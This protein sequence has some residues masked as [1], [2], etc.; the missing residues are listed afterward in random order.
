M[1][2]FKNILF[3]WEREVESKGA[4]TRAVDLAKRNGGRLKIVQVVPSFTESQDWR[5]T[6]KLIA[7]LEPRMIEGAQSYLKNIVS[8]FSKAGIPIQSEILVGTPFLCVVREVMKKGH[9]LVMMAA[10]GKLGLKDQLFGSTSWH[11]MRKCPCPVWIFKEQR[12]SRFKRIIA[13]V[14]P[15]AEDKRKTLLNI[16]ILELASSLAR[17][18]ESDLHIVHAWDVYG[19]ARVWLSDYDFDNLEHQE[20]INQK[21]QLDALVQEQKLDAL[22]YHVHLAQ[23]HAKNVIPD[24]VAKYRIDLIVMGTVC[25]TGLAGFIIGNTA[26]D[27]LRQINCSV[28]TVKPEGFV[29]PIRVE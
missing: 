10:E 9:D 18:E 25:R 5:Y 28:L 14:D 24:A 13:A 8:S 1:E 7:D 6:N 17:M 22:K 11:L 21:R 26:E 12:Q 3:L 20:K 4:L 27:I 16:K 15:D 29:S 19:S 2:R 23:G